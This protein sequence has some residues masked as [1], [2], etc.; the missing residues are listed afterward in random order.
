VPLAA[1]SVISCLSRFATAPEHV[2]IESVERHHH[3]HLGHKPG[4]ASN[5]RQDGLTRPGNVLS[6]TT[7]D[8]A[9]RVAGM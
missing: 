2:R 5:W 1:L 9:G 3:P 8:R 4:Q 7:W 6:T